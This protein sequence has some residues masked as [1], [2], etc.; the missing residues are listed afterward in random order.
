MVLANRPRLL[1]LEEPTAGMT[2]GETKRTEALLRGLGQEHTIVVIEH[3]VRFIRE[4][5]ERVVV[6]HRGK[7]LASGPID[8]VERDERV[9]D[10]YLGREE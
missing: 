5:A 6:L 2:L 4:V 3:D 10:V 8:Q 7:V 1:L 9:R